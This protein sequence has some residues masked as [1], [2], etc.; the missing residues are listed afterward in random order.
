[1]VEGEGKKT[2]ARALNSSPLCNKNIWRNR[3]TNTYR[4]TLNNG[5]ISG[6]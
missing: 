6:F 1:M 3:Y 5:V 2:F 4:N